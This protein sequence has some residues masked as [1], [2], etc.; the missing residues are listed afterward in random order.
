MMG[1]EKGK[2]TFCMFILDL[3]I[4]EAFKHQL[5]LVYARIVHSL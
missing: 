1:G 3:D 5:Y 4:S 2:E